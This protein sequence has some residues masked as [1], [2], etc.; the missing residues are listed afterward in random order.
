M[1]KINTDGSFCVESSS[2][3]WGY[4]NRD[5]DGD[6]VVTAAGRL[7]HAQDVLQTEAEACLQALYKAQELGI[8]RVVVET[9]AMLLVQAIK[10]SNFDLSPN[11]VLFRE[12]KAFA[13][14]NFS[15]FC[16]INCPRACNKITD[17]L[18]LYGLK[19]ELAPQ[20]VWPG[21]APTFAQSLAACDSVR[22]ID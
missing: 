8:S 1:L 14:L 13:T 4:I 11:G 3:G 7:A 16:V 20:A 9:E 12:I 15:D 18:A 2:G 19:M 10:T 5:H 17:V 21:L 22:H 6:V